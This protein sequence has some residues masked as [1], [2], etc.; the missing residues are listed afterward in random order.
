MGA[1]PQK[2][3]R[4]LSLKTVLDRVPYSANHLA[5]LEATGDFPKRIKLSPNRVVWVEEEIDEY[6][7]RKIRE[8][9][10]AAE[11]PSPASEAQQ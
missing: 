10:E 2:P 7:E 8:R 3:R 1:K 9:N 4:F 11:A 6:Q 5:R